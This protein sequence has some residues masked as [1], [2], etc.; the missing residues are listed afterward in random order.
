MAWVQLSFLVRV[1]RYGIVAPL[2]QRRSY[3][4]W[5]ACAI[6]LKGEGRTIGLRAPLVPKSN[7]GH[8]AC[9]RHWYKRQ[10]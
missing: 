6:G 9:M 1:K 7:L 3:E 5:L 10:S 4:T 8:L 2:V